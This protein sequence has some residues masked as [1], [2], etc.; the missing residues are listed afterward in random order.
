[1]NTVR[2]VRE[3]KTSLPRRSGLGGFE[4]IPALLVSTA[5]LVM[6]ACGGGSS[7]PPPAEMGSLVVN[8]SGVPAG[9]TVSVTVTGPSGFSQT[10]SQ[11]TT[12]TNLTAGKYAVAAPILPPASS[13]SLIVPTYSSNPTTVA[14]GAS[15]STT[16]AYG[17]L[18]LSWQR[19]GPRAIQTSYLSG[20]YGA[21]QIGA[22]A[23][24]NADPSTIYV[25]CAGWYGP[26][27]S[28]G[29]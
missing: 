13:S 28:T 8:I 24:N 9:S 18:N 14:G 11:T 2:S 7:L 5:C 1:M 3:S 20:V 26:A 27:S 4:W 17:S 25:S 16:V 12:L 6:T 19:I 22:I 21:G 10:I 23:V 29:V 15:A